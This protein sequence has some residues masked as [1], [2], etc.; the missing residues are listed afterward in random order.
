MIAA[1]RIKYR[2][3]KKIVWSEY[4]RFRIRRVIWTKQASY[5]NDGA[6]AHKGKGG[7]GGSGG[8][9]FMIGGCD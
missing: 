8:Q 6:Q 9:L 5:R 3:R 1:R 4:K 2:T 7:D